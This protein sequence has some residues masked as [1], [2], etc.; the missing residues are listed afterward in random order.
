[1]HTINGAKRWK[2]QVAETAGVLEVAFVCPSCGR[3]LQIRLQP[4]PWLEPVGEITEDALAAGEVVHAELDEITTEL[5][6]HRCQ[7][8]AEVTVQQAVQEG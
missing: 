5:W 7:I 3:D 1:M 2:P 4:P 8:G 6:C